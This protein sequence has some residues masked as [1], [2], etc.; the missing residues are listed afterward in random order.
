[1]RA[2][3][4]RVSGAWVDVVGEAGAR[5]VAEIGRGLLVLVG[6]AVGDEEHDASWIAAKVAGLRVF[7]D[8]SGKMNLGL[9][10]VGGAVLLVPNFTVAGDAQ[11]GRRPSFDSAMRAPES[12]VLFERVV[13]LVRVATP[14]LVVREGVFGGEMRVG[15]INEGPVTVV[16]DSRR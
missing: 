14:G 12:R 6:A 13:E 3:V 9:E 16:V 1:M 15:L 5:R 10:E 7:E 4:Q 8:A 2:V 11:K